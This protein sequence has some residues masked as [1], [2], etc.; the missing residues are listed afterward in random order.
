MPNQVIAQ[1]EQVITSRKNSSSETSYVASLNKKGLDQI[2]KKVIE[3]AGETLM[4][5]KDHQHINTSH[6]ADKV[7]YE[8]ADLIF[9]TIVMLSHQNIPFS[10]VEEEIARRFGSSG[11]DEK[12]SRK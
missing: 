8:V 1:L 2:L 3:E 10:A 5:A 4:A 12:N 7:V 9:H 11:I 6:S